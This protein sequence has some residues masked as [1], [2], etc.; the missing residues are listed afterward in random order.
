VEPTDPPEAPAPTPEPEP[1]PDYLLKI[2]DYQTSFE[3]LE[4]GTLDKST[5]V[6]V[7][8]N[9]DTEYDRAVEILTRVSDLGYL[10]RFQ[11]A[12]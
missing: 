2:G 7:V 5:P 6:T 9:P 10:V 11:A 3:E 4:S 12:P 8:M 1:E